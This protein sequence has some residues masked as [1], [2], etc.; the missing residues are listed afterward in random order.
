MHGL[1]GQ[2][3]P[4]WSSV[5]AEAQAVRRAAAETRQPQGTAV[6]ASVDWLERAMT[7]HSTQTAMRKVVGCVENKRRVMVKREEAVD[8]AAVVV[9]H[10]M[11]L[12]MSEEKCHWMWLMRTVKAMVEVDQMQD[13]HHL[14]PQARSLIHL[15]VGEA[16][17]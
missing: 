14:H 16:F 15:R 13:L 3:R 1:F 9:V 10:V 6:F 12:A 4:P 11:K 5:T 8:A 2:P 17:H 7:T